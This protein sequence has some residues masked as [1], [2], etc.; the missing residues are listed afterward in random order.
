MQKNNEPVSLAPVKSAWTTKPA[1]GMGPN[2]HW[3]HGLSTDANLLHVS[4]Q[5]AN[6]IAAARDLQTTLKDLLSAMGSEAEDYYPHATQRAL[7]ALAK[8][9]GILA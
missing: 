5:E 9:N 2:Y 7:A 3:V 8:S 6:L 1:R 4:E